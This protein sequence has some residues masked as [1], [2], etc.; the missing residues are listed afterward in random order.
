MQNYTKKFEKF[1]SLI[2]NKPLDSNPMVQCKNVRLG[3]KNNFWF[4][5][6]ID[7]KSGK[8]AYNYSRCGRF[9][10]AVP[11][12]QFNELSVVLYNCVA[13]P[14]YLYYVYGVISMGTQ[15][16]NCRGA[17][18]CA[19]PTYR[20]QTRDTGLFG[21]GRMSCVACSETYDLGLGIG[22]RTIYMMI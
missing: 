7:S 18:G 21:T 4:Q 16:T 14:V 1:D 13:G 19:V 11:H 8:I 3:P 10:T 9:H 17:C 12:N 2:I 5:I 15:C 22:N 6:K 20:E